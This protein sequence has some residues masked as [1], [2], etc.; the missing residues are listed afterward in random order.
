MPK[1][2]RRSRSDHTIQRLSE[3]V[4]DAAAQMKNKDELASFFN[5]LLTRTEKAMLGKR[6]LI[7]LL[8]R[9]GYSYA[10]IEDWLEVSQTT[11][12]GVSERL[13]QDGGIFELAMK[14]L[15]RSRRIE[16]IVKRVEKALSTFPSKVGPGRWRFLKDW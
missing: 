8:L 1:L 13:H 5:G 2:S 3:E 12:A 15:E 14:R 10:H 7:A 6:V 4:V 16:E 11:I 9:K